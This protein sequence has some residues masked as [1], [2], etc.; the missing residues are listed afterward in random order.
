MPSTDGG[1]VFGASDPGL[2]DSA[3]REYSI[4]GQAPGI[5]RSRWYC[6]EFSVDYKQVEVEN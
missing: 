2:A 3:R 6:I 4:P 1:G 5:V